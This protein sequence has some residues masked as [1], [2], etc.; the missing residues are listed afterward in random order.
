[1]EAS[2]GYL[3]SNN[4]YSDKTVLV[5]T[6]GAFI[7]RRLGFAL[8]SDV[9]VYTRFY[10]IQLDVSLIFHPISRVHLEAGPDL[11]LVS[12]ESQAV[13]GGDANWG[14]Y[15]SGH[16]GI[17][18]EVHNMVALFLTGFAGPRTRMVEA[19][20]LSIWTNDDRFM[21]GYNV[22]FKLQ[23]IPHFTADVAFVHY[24]GT[25]RQGMSNRF[26]VPGFS[27]GLSCEF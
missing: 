4:I 17:A 27:V 7:P 15:A 6:G 16:L 14:V 1:L 23:G 8:S 2:G 9:S 20:G 26:Y 10:V 19:S 11:I 3:L 21:G 25:F 13:L 18:A 12:D 22:G 5:H 24:I